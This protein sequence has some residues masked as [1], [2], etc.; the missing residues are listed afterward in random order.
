M[1]P[2]NDTQEK[3]MYLVGPISAALSVVGSSTILYML[4]LRKKK[5]PYQRIL[6]VMSL[7]DI[8]FSTTAACMP[9]L[10]PESGGR[11]WAFGDQA[12]CNVMGF[13]A[14]FGMA[15]YLYNINLSLYFNLTI[16]H[17]MSK[18]RFA[19]LAEPW[20]HGISIGFPLVTAIAGLA[21]QLHDETPVGLNC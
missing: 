1:A 21:L 4:Y 7:N 8:L 3:I 2:L 13:F 6:G 19:R 15:T 17:C 20:M 14:Q 5:D 12:S 9:F 16:V 11:V 10:L 18:T